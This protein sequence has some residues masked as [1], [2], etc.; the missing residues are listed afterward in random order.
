MYNIGSVIIVL[1]SWSLFILFYFLFFV[2]IPMACVSCWARDQTRAI[3]TT[4]ATAI[5]M[6]DP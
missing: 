4:Q 2:V 1:L 3:A 6:L 5:A